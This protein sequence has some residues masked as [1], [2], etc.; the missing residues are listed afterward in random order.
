MLKHYA[1]KQRLG[2]LLKILVGFCLALVISPLFSPL[3][4]LAHSATTP[5]TATNGPTL[6]VDVGYDATFK[7]GYWTPVHIGISSGAADFAGTL[8]VNTYSGL[9]VHRLLAYSHPGVFSNL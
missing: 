1:P 2:T 8:A 5:A 3:Q 9:L 7:T 4:A 6:Q